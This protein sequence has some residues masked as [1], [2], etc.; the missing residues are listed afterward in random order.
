[1]WQQSD[2]Q[3][4]DLSRSFCFTFY[5][6]VWAHT[7]APGF[8][9]WV[10]EGSRS[11]AVRSKGQGALMDGPDQSWQLPRRVRLVIHPWW[12][13]TRSLPGP[14]FCTRKQKAINTWPPRTPST[15]LGHAHCTWMPLCSHNRTL[16]WAW[17]RTHGHRSALK[18]ERPWEI[19]QVAQPGTSGTQKR[20]R[21]DLTRGHNRG[22]NQRGSAARR[23]MWAKWQGAELATPK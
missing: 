3:W 2:I 4:C 18:S 10:G 20:A 17:R 23:T 5:Y 15:Q 19:L 13:I 12:I 14:Q 16:C 9:G 1:M 6:A 21:L 7:D 8:L 11:W 22:G